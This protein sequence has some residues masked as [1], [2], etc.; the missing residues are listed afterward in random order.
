[1]REIVQSL[2]EVLESKTV[3]EQALRQQQE[4]M[5]KQLE[6]AQGDLQRSEETV[7]SLRQELGQLREEYEKGEIRLTWLLFIVNHY[8]TLGAL[9]ERCS[10]VFLPT[11]KKKKYLLRCTIRAVKTAYSANFPG[12]LLV[13]VLCKKEKNFPL[14]IKCTIHLS[15][16]HSLSGTR[17]KSPKCCNL[18]L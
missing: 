9:Q 13:L 12:C 17:L 3:M 7:Q 11:T 4:A 1:M 16:S 2:Q 18:P 15:Q 6:T 14:F 5:E 8:F 10:R